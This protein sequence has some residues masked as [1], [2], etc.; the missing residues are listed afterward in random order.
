VSNEAGMG[1]ID[2]RKGAEIDLEVEKLA[3]GGKA[4]ARLNGFVVFVDHA[5]P[6]QTVRVKITRKKRQ[7]AEGI[8]QELLAQSP[9]YIAPFCPHFGVCGGCSWQD[10]RYE[11][12][13]SWKRRHVLEA[14]EHLAGVSEARV[15]PTVPSPDTIWYRNKMDFTFSNRSWVERPDAAVDGHGHGASVALGL[16]V[17][18]SFSAVLNIE[19]CFLESPQAVEILKEARQWCQNSGLPA[20]NI[21][22]HEGFWRFLVIREGKR[23]DQILVHLLTTSGAGNVVIVDDL[24]N[25]LRARFPCL[26]TFV[27]SITDSKAQ[28]AS[29]DFSRAL[30]GPGFIEDRMGTLQFRISPHSFFQTNPIAA[31]QLYSA[32]LQVG[33][34]TGR[35]TVWDLYCGTGSIALFIA[36]HARQVMGFE[37]SE[38]AIEDAYENCGL[39]GIENCSFVSGDLKDVIRNTRGPEFREIQPDVVITDPPRSGMHPHVLKA[40]IEAGPDRIIAVSCNPATLAR[41]L[42]A[43]LQQYEIETVQ[44]FD[45]FPHTPHIECL[46]KLK[47]K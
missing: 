30:F 40:L 2:I 28:V 29:G 34:F 3:F 20:Y 12:Q 42:V 33:E 27:H 39:N 47:K 11:E 31:H 4:L 26:T 37:V 9:H 5:I 16:H 6:G 1:M 21:K 45:L 25:H 35:E 13:L 22:N 8:V 19:S 23:T 17:R 41:D 7:F 38:E 43:L 36:A 46:V 14:L 18:K 44:P 24:A 15:L 32:I 10:L